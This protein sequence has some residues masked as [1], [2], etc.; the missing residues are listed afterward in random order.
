MAVDAHA[1][2]DEPAVLRAAPGDGRIDAEEMPRAAREEAD[3]RPQGAVEPDVGI[4]DPGTVEAG[5]VFRGPPS[6]LISARHELSHFFLREL[7]PGGA[8]AG[9]IFA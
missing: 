8:T 5:S 6:G 4:R 7:Q 1:R 2:F 3:G 9:A